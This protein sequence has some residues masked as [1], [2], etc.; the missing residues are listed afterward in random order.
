MGA[1]IK[2]LSFSSNYQY[3]THAMR[4]NAA[5]NR[6]PRRR[7]RQR[8][9]SAKVTQQDATRQ[10]T[11]TLNRITNVNLS[12]ISPNGGTVQYATVLN[13]LSAF[14]GSSTLVQQYEQFRITRIRV[15]AR[16]D[17][18]NVL[19][20]NPQGRFLAAYSLAEFSTIATF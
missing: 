14:A 1:K 16:T 3:P 13:P 15:Y 10:T 19:A 12:A 18:S 2:F 11:R 7:V 20:L 8:P 9:A 6:Q 17:A 4:R 5:Q